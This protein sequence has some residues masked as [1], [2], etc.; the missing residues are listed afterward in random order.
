MGGKTFF[1]WFRSGFGPSVIEG[2]SYGRATTAVIVG[3]TTAVNLA[4]AS[5][6]YLIGV[7]IGSWVSA[8]PVYG[9]PC[10]NIAEWWGNYFYVLGNNEQFREQMEQLYLASH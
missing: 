1:Q 7:G 2:W 6:G 8:I 4:Y 3:G 9:E 5:S 10:T